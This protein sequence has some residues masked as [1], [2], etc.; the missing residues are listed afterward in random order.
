MAVQ[1]D[2]NKSIADRRSGV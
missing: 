1:Q 2:Y